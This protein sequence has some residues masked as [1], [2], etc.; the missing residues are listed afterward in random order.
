MLSCEMLILDVAN[1]VLFSLC[2]NRTNMV[3]NVRIFCHW[4][5]WSSI[6]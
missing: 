6:C 3:S 1:D 2:L 4:N 5:S